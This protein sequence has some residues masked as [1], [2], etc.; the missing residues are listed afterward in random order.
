MPNKLVIISNDKFY[1]HNNDYFC[2]HIAEKTLAD[3]LNNKFEV[4]LIGRKTN[5]QRSHRLKNTNIEHYNFI[6]SYLYAILKKILK[7]ESKFLI[8]AISP[9]TFLASLLFIFSKQKPIVYLRSDG[10]QE[11]KSI[12]GFYGPYI[13]NFMFIIVSKLG[14]L[15][16]CR[17]HILRDKP[18]K[19]VAPSEITKNWIENYSKPEF[20]SIK[21]LYVGRMNVEKGIYSL[22]EIL[23]NISSEI[24]LTI[25]GE[26]KEKKK[27][28]SK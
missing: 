19:V 8:Q 17:K 28:Y 15:I 21:L 11:Y 3:E 9:Y 16:S 24:N 4:T 22:L 25:I 7:K 27:K 1:S 14:L 23:N 5:I 6:F 13:Y 2:D 10:F 26:S 18:G 20:K 12:L